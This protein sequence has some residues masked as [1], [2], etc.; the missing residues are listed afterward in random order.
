[1]AMG[2]PLEMDAK[3]SEHHLSMAISIAML[4]SDIQQLWPFTSY[5]WLFL[6][7]YTFYKWGFLST[8]N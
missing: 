8:Y 6:W 5:N 2:N 7:D 1:M 3:Q 4:N